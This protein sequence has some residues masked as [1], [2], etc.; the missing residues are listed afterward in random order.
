[1]HHCHDI[2]LCDILTCLQ[3]IHQNDPKVCVDCRSKR[4]ETRSRPIGWVRQNAVPIKFDSKPSE[5]AFSTV[6]C[7]NFRLEEVI[8]VISGAV[9]DQAGMDALAN[10]YHSL[11]SV[12]HGTRRLDVFPLHVGVKFG[13]SRSRR[14]R[15]I[16]PAHFV[17]D[18][19]TNDNRRRSKV[20]AYRQK[21]HT[22][23]LKS[24]D[25]LGLI[26]IVV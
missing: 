14:F 16:R 1:M 13:D 20:M 26:W 12:F 11:S 6:F 22:G 24:P 2:V 25:V 3:H 10:H 4:S 5:A 23:P 7:D 17:M 19:R 8:D 15:D 21:R 9:I 18:E